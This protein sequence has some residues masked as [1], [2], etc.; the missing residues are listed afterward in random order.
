MLVPQ[1][2]QNTPHSGLADLAPHRLLVDSHRGDDLGEG[3]EVLDPGALFVR[4]SLHTYKK[5]YEKE[6]KGGGRRRRG[7]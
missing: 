4:Q 6:E 7:E 2:R 5:K 1:R 3:L